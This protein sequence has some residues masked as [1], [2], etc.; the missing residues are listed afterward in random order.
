MNIKLLGTKFF[1]NTKLLMFILGIIIGSSLLSSCNQIRLESFSSISDNSVDNKTNNKLMDEW[2]NNAT[3]FA[4]TN[5]NQDHLI[6]N[7]TYN[8]NNNFNKDNDLFFF[9]ETAAKP[10][11][12]PSTYSNS[13]GCLCAS[14][15]QNNFLNQR[16]ENRSYG[17]Y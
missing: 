15:E 12:C 9:T 13:A 8:G 14:P 7:Q 17:E 5:L 4:E 6:R 10:E 16:G 11:C 3:E 1:T 2:T